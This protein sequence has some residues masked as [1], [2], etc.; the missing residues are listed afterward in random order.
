MPEPITASA[1]A[2]LLA[3]KAAEQFGSRLGDEIANGVFGR[4]R[5]FTELKKM[6]KQLNAKVDELLH[7][8]KAT[9]KLVEK[10][11]YVIQNEFT[12]NSLNQ[13]HEEFE[14]IKKSI[15]LM[16]EWRDTITKDNFAKI[17]KSWLCI[18]DYEYRVD[19]ITKLPEHAEF[20][21]LITNGRALEMIT[22]GID[23]KIN[24]FEGAS[25]II[26]EQEITPRALE[27]ERILKSEFITSGQLL[28]GDPWAK[29]VLPEKKYNSVYVPCQQIGGQTLLEDENLFFCGPGIEEDRPFNYQVSVS[30]D[31]LIK[32]TR[33][34]SERVP[35]L[36]TNELGINLLTKYKKSIVNR[37]IQ[38]NPGPE[39]FMIE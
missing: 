15:E 13:A 31:S 1:L 3:A 22:S 12:K 14:A 28:D 34:I 19:E 8:A 24:M 18:I 23:S 39:L 38:N 25:R 16:P 37:N 6:L 4:S 35:D 17:V 5:D 7:Y 9:Y 30:N 36:V 11:P 33:E 29:W 10:L 21:L 32:L 27:I 2:A 26:K 20:I